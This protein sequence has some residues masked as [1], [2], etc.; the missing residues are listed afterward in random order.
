MEVKEGRIQQRTM[1]DYVI[2]TSLDVPVIENDFVLNPYE[3]GIFGA[4]GAGE[5]V[6]NGGAP[7]F[8]EAVQM[9]AGG[10]FYSIPLTPEKIME[11]LK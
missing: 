2:P 7:A 4:K 3:D 8:L 9:A 10:R 1:A 6:H 5:I 11:K